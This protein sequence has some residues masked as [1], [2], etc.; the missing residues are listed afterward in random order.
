VVRVAN[1]GTTPASGTV[2]LK[3][4]VRVKGKLRTQVVG[5]AKVTV[6]AGR[7]KTITV[8]IRPGARAAFAGGK[9]PKLTAQL[10]LKVAGGERKTKSTT[11]VVSR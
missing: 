8:T 5:T 10:T 3:R 2:T 4:T 1:T 6:A 7:T 9:R 11:V